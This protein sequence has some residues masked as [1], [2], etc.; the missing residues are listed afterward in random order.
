MTNAERFKPYFTPTE[1]L[2]LTLE[3]H[4]GMTVSEIASTL[5]LSHNETLFI[6]T[7]AHEKARRIKE[8]QDA[9]KSERSS[10]VET[11]PKKEP[12]N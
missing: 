7:S 1:S 2:L 8:L 4:E 6:R 3:W 5:G 10:E 11:N 9:R 12:S